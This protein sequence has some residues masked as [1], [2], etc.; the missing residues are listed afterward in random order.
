MVVVLI[1][2]TNETFDTTSDASILC[3]YVSGLSMVLQQNKI[4]VVS[5]N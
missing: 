2:N 4:I 3:I 5:Q 1:R